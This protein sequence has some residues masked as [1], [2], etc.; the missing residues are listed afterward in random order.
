[1]Y[2]WQAWEQPPR[3]ASGMPLG[4]WW[5][6]PTPGKRGLAIALAFLRSYTIPWIEAYQYIWLLCT[7]V[8][9]LWI[10][11]FVHSSVRD[12]F[13]IAWGDCI[14][15]VYICSFSTLGHSGVYTMA[16]IEIDEC[17]KKKSLCMQYVCMYVCRYVCIHK[18][19]YIRIYV[20]MHVYINI[21]VYIRM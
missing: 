2:V 4:N 7:D 9:S 3:G 17:L 18:S 16:S 13:I 8:K 10:H 6:P 5:F 14:V 11:Y 19:T 1:M 20:C 21:I 15:S 12:S